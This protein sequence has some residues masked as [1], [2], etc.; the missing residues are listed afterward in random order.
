MENITVILSTTLTKEVEV[1][2]PYGL[3]NETL[4][5]AHFAQKRRREKQRNKDERE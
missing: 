1:K 3:Q 2:Y 5:N 4:K